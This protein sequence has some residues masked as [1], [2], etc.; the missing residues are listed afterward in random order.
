MFRK[1]LLTVAAGVVLTA[2]LAAPTA[3]QAFDRYRDDHR[4]WRDDRYR[5]RDRD[6]DRDHEQQLALPDPGNLVNFRGQN[7]QVF[8]F[9][10]TGNRNAGQVWGA[11]LYTDDSSLAAA[12]VHAGVLRDGETGVVKVTILPGAPGYQGA[13]RNGVGSGNWGGWDG[14]Y[15]IDP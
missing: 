8:Y 2:G 4:G 7:G 3:A 15:R 14:S 5:D 1:W 9:E 10:V 12:A 13:F 11:G 6:R